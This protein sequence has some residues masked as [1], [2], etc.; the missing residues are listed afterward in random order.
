MSSELPPV[1]YQRLEEQRKNLAFR[2]LRNADPA[3]TDFSSND[4]LGICRNRMISV[5][6]SLAH[7]STGSRLLS[8]NSPEAEQLETFLANFHSSEAALL[9]NSGYDANLGLL[10]SLPKEGDTILYDILSHA[11][12]RD[13]I[14]LSRA[15]AFPFLHNDMIDLERRLSAA[16]GTVYVVSESVF[17]MDGDL[18]PLGP[19]VNLC[20][21]FGA[22][23]IVDEAHATGVIG[24]RGEGLVQQLGLENR[25]MARIHTFGKA[26]GCHGAVVLG[27]LALKEFLLNF[28]R[29][30]IYATA[31]SPVAVA[32]IKAS[33]GIFPAMHEERKGIAELIAYF[34]SLP[35]PC[36]KLASSTP[37][38][39]II[40]PGNQE[41]AAL[42]ERLLL[43]GFDCRPIRYPTVPKG[44]ERIRIILHAFNTL[45]EL[46][47][48]KKAI[49]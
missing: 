9:F 26:V 45:Q 13:G 16:T 22:Y 32:A 19:M 23:L 37:I 4:Y 12:I 33:Y 15:N 18:A 1:I 36:T 21:K 11:S 29:P 47:L 7:G 39:G 41:V 8:G 38:Q 25:V 49:S 48:L 27:S 43:A 20:Q 6:P 35:L 31:M 5:S 3:L 34:Q 14:R 30:L 10:S 17:S 42:S 44:R 24:D 2:Q 40:I 28:C 46:D